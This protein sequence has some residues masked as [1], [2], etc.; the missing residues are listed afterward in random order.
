[1]TPAG[2]VIRNQ[3]MA[4]VDGERYLSNVVETVVRPLCL[5]S[6]TPN[7]TPAAPGQVAG[8]TPAGY[9][10]LPY[11]LTNAGN[12]TFTFSLSLLLGPRDWDPEE[13]AIFPDQNADGLPDGPIPLAQATLA[14]G[15]TLRL[16]VGI[17]APTNAA[18]T[19]LLTPVARCPSGQEDADNY[20]RITV[21]T[22]PALTVEKQMPLRAL[23]GEEIPVL[24]RV[25][26]L[27]T[28]TAQGVTV[29]DYP[30]PLPFVPG[31]AQA[32]KG[33]VEYHDGTTWQPS[34]PQVVKGVRLVLD[35]LLAGEEATLAF[36]LQ[37]PPMA[38]PGQVENL[39]QALGPGG[40]AEG[41]AVLE[42]LPRHEHH[43]GPFGNPRAL[44]GG[45]GSRD[46]RQ[47]A[48]GLTGQPLC[49][50]HTLEN[51]GTV[52]DSYHLRV[53]GLP[54]GLGYWLMGMDGTPLTPPL[55][56]EPGERV[57]FKVCYLPQEA[58]PF[59]A[60]VV[61][62]SQTT[63]ARNAT[64][65]LLQ[66]LPASALNLIKEADPAPGTTLRPGDEI[67]YTLRIQN[68][69]APLS[70]V[71]VE[72]ALSPHVEFLSA[73]HGGTYDAQNHKVAWT[74]AALPQGET[75]LTLRVRVRA[76]A[77][78]D[79]LVENTFLLR[80]QET[81]NPI[82]SNPVTHP[83][84]GVN[85]LLKKE[86]TPKEAVVGDLLTYRLTLENPSTA[87]LTVR[88]KDTPPSGTRYEPGT[89]RL[90]PGCQ[91][92]GEA[93]EP[94]VENGTLRWENLPLPGK[95]KLCLSYQLRL[96]PGAPKELVN[97][98][99]ALGLSGNGAA[100]ASGKAQALAVQKPGPFALEGVLLGRVF[101]DLDED[102]RYGPG[103]IPLPAARVL[104]ANGTQALTD[105]S[106]RYAFR[107]LSG[108]HQV[109]LDPASAPFPPVPLPMDLGEGYRKRV[110]V[111][112]VT[113]VDFPL[114]APKGVVRVLRSTTLSLGPFR[115][116]KRLL[117][118]GG[119]LL[120]EL[121]LKSSESLP[122][123]TLTDPLPQGGER[124]F[125]FEAFQG[126]EVLT[127]ELKEAILTDPEVRWRYP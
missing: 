24:L 105:A 89:A 62:V 52:R 58:G 65:D 68:A 10:Y 49:F 100:T 56:L 80:S 26:N 118:V 98:A 19:T 87:A 39:A 93:L 71:V 36:R 47:T 33:R 108:L 73:S 110:V 27:G 1:M 40:P 59:Q 60:V 42:V 95:G 81:P 45:E 74:L 124:A 77:P 90:F 34:E 91:G 28:A 103:D 119:K 53:E 115:V 29:V 18:G 83:V 9:A 107:E 72:D 17:R 120:V 44:P 69:F 6:L 106:G 30:L 96:L 32:P 97:T 38:S 43:L 31:S 84:F 101:L 35:R 104:L 123:L 122:D 12:D 82:V 7:G 55:V 121:R 22:G 15:E 92:S 75:L 16:V 5:P 85:L 48:Q 63:G 116:E 8:V 88:L 102:G 86:V 125:H 64:T 54:E 3:A 25:R 14:M 70:Q 41:R 76:D 99:E 51:A 126:E 50:A 13:M 113:V 94:Q 66:V 114:K 112:G 57:D 4:L 117:E 2:T 78:D 109:M 20:A 61:A 127:Y 67:T 21:T 111:Q 79:T 23:P 37:V 11:V 46:D